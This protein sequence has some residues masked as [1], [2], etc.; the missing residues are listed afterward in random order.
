[1]TISERHRKLL[2]E[3]KTLGGETTA[4]QT[5]H[6]GPGCHGMP[7]KIAFGFA[8]QFPELDI[9]YRHDGGWLNRSHLLTAKGPAV[10]VVVFDITLDDVLRS[11]GVR[12]PAQR[13]AA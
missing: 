4:R 8:R 7:R 12:R 6:T 3:A 1:M 10:D 13:A 11:R 9:T 5:F 2:R